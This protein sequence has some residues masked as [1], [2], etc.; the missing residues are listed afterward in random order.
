MIII[1]LSWDF[2]NIIIINFLFFMN[3][4]VLFNPGFKTATNKDG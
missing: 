4:K 2:M 3:E 1:L